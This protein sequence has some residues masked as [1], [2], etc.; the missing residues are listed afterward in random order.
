MGRLGLIASLLVGLACAGDI[1]DAGGGAADADPTAPDAAP[2]SPD[3]VPGSPDA[4]V[5][6]G[7]PA[8]LAGITQLHNDVRAMVGVGPMTWDPE[9]AAVA[10]AW[11][12][13]C[14]D[15]QSPIGLIDHNAGRSENYPG[16]VGENIY[17]SGGSATAAGAVG[18]WAAEGADYDYASN[19]CAAGKVCGHYTQ[20]VWAASVKLGCALY[21]CPGL[22][23]GSSIVCNYAPGGNSGGRPY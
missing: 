16:Y 1:D 12:S 3:A 5:G 23:Y 21:D 20:V 9:L 7:E 19:S 22:Q 13:Q 18:L 2:G 15:Q 6:L 17:G 4:N 8:N 11:A 10:M 14:V